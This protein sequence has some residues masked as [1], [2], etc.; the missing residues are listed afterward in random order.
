MLFD[1]MLQLWRPDEHRSRSMTM[2]Y[3]RLSPD[4]KRDAVRLLEVPAPSAPVDF[5]ALRAPS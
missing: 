3:G 1:A 2:R 4:V 5:G